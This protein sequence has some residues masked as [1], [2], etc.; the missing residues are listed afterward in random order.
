[1][2]ESKKATLVTDGRTLIPQPRRGLFPWGDSFDHVKEGMK[3]HK[4]E[5]FGPVLVHLRAS[6]YEEAISIINNHEYGNGTAI[7]TKTG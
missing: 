6:T 4:E 7:F 2:L 3:I 5:I 1:M